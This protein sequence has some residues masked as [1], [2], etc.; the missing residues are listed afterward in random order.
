MIRVIRLLLPAA[1][2]LAALIA[3]PAANAAT[4]P[5]RQST[6]WNIAHQG[7]EDEF[8][9]NTMY[10]FKEA[11]KAGANMLE[12]DVSATKDNQVVVMHDTTV[13][14]KTNGHGE[15]QS[16]TLKQ[17]QK[18]DAAYWYSKS[19]GHYDRDKPKSAYPYRGIATGR[20]KPP[21]GYTAADFRVATLASV[22]KAFPTMPINVE[23]KGRTKQE[24]VSEY[25]K[26]AN[27]LAKL[28]KPVK[29]KNIVVVSFKQEAT[30]RFHQL[31][32][33]FPLA[34]GTSGAEAYLLGG[35]S[36]GDG[37]E[38][39]QLPVTYTINGALLLVAS[40]DF[41]QKVHDGGYA[42]HAWFG[43]QDPDTPATWQ[44]LVD[45]CVDG[46]MTARPKALETFLKSHPSPAA[47]K[48]S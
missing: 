3:V 37:M 32:P 23:I 18:L 36:P 9:S 27:I 17:I 5:W 30:D 42:W 25:V 38:V 16:F 20:K 4:N 1:L 31:D 11:V 22:L 46:I 19:A 33:Q 21:K 7:G 15:V 14:S 29:R 2:L 8:P 13:D 48:V 45:V 10:A 44:K 28:L 34:P 47:C 12:L 40:K 6:P 26:N 24:A 43:D 39:F 41:V 35:T